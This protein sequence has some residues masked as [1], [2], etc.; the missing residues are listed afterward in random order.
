[1]GKKG[2]KKAAAEPE[3]EI[4]PDLKE[5]CR[6]AAPLREC[7]GGWLVGRKLRWKI[8]E[9]AAGIIMFT[10]IEPLSHQ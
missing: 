1:M 10:E 4:D 5:I 6:S 2:K 7:G 9:L 8:F 3:V